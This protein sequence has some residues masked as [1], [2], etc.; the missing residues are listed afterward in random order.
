M[1]TK[2]GQKENLNK[3]MNKLRLQNGPSFK[4]NSE[5]STL[6]VIR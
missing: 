4:K 2:I 3:F 6:F 5:N 1:N